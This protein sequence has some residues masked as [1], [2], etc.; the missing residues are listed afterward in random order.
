VI[1][2][3]LEPRSR[4]LV[5]QGGRRVGS[6]L[7]GPCAGFLFHCYSHPW[8]GLSPAVRREAIEALFARPEHLDALLD[9][10]ES[11][12]ISASDLEPTRQK[13]LLAHPLA[14]VRGRAE[15]IL[16]GHAR[17]DR[18][19]VI[20]AFRPALSTAGDRANGKEVFGKACAACHRAEGQGFEVGPNLA[21]VT[22]RTPEDLLIHVLDPNREVAPNYLN[23]AVETVDGLT[24][25]GLIAEESAN[26]VTL[27]RAGGA[28]DLVPR[29]RIE[30]IA[31]TGLSLM[32]EELEAGLE[33]KNLA[34]LISYIRSIQSGGQTISIR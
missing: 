25:T 20:A 15:T 11:K 21:T 31:S 7:R 24:L 32:P 29:N 26:A 19:A 1:V 6:N 2:R 30:S 12:A 13:Q 33:P 27:K 23:Y 18:N 3:A 8:K 9:A 10:L 28:T 16:R 34:D 22:G 17:P 4:K 14:S 5:R